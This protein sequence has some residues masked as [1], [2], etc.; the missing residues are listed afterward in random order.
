MEHQSGRF[1]IIT[2]SG[3]GKEEEEKRYFLFIFCAIFYLQF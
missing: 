2:S 3:E 1:W